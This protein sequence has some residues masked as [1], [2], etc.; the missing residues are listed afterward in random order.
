MRSV[1]VHM[2]PQVDYKDRICRGIIF[3]SPIDIRQFSESLV[4]V[5]FKRFLLGYQRSSV[6]HPWDLQF[7]AH[8]TVRGSLS[9]HIPAWVRAQTLLWL[10]TP[11]LSKSKSKP[12]QL[13]PPPAS[14]LTLAPASLHCSVHFSPPAVSFVPCVCPAWSH[15]DILPPLL[16]LLPGRVLLAI[17]FL[18]I[19]QSWPRSRLVL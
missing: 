10:S 1:H 2:L 6:F 14:S 11:P 4:T 7:T 8:T 18:T 3:F 15:D 5:C 12:L 13:P 19:F 17:N 9:K 16:F